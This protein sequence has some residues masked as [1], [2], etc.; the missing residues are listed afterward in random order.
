M[1]IVRLENFFKIKLFRFLE[2]IWHICSTFI[3]LVLLK[4]KISHFSLKVF[5]IEIHCSNN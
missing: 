4:T 2:N 1:L 5:F 3:A